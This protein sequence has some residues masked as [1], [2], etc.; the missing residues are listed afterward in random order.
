MPIKF[1]CSKCGAML[2]APDEAAGRRAK[3]NKCGTIVI[4]P[5]AAD[6]LWPPGA[7]PKPPSQPPSPAKAPGTPPKGPPKAPPQPPAPQTAKPKPKGPAAPP[8][9]RP[10]KPTPPPAAPPPAARAPSVGPFDLSAADDV[11]SLFDEADF[12]PSPP[13]PQ[14]VPVVVPNPYQSP[15]FDPAARTGN[16]VAADDVRL[17][18]GDWALA[19]LCGNIACILG[20][21]WILRGN[22]KG[23]KMIVACLAA[24]GGWIVFSI[25]VRFILAILG[26]SVR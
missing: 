15:A 9:P 6:H 4:V 7:A 26:Q 3:C 23:P 11:D 21:Y 18:P 24:T 1:Q 14:P 16:R 20:L 25:A 8:Q 13:A 10:T 22:P 2:K 17:T 5:S 12:A 19:I